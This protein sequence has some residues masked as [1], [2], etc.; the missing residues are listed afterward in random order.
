MKH[1]VRMEQPT[2]LP[3]F[4]DIGSESSE[5]GEVE[6]SLEEW[7]RAENM[8]TARGNLDDA[9]LA[10]RLG[11]ERTTVYR[12]RTGK[13]NVSGAFIDA[14]IRASGGRVSANRFFDRAYTEAA[15]SRGGEASD[16]PFSS[17]SSA[18]QPRSRPAADAARPPRRSTSRPEAASPSRPRSAN[19]STS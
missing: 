7:M 19:R 11:M 13:Y 18:R 8:I 5:T 16:S 2:S 10:D 17:T 14:V 1:I 4:A 6:L 3:A 12:T 15:A 9:A